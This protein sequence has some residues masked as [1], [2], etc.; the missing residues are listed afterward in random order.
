MGYIQDLE[1]ELRERLIELE[2]GKEPDDF[3]K[4]VKDKVWESYRNGQ[5][6]A[7][8]GAEGKGAGKKTDKPAREKEEA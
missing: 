7:K 4:F 3:V 8:P 5:K 2:I 6:A 1:K